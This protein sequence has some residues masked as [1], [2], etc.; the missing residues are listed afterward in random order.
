MEVRQEIKTYSRK[1]PVTTFA[2]AATLV[3]TEIRVD[4]NGYVRPSCLNEKTLIVHNLE[5]TFDRV[6]QGVM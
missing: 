4:N 5:D 6:A 1:K 3:P 2:S